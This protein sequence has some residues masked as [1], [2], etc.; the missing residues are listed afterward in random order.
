MASPVEGVSY[1]KI[2]EENENLSISHK[3]GET[4]GEA[5]SSSS[6]QAQLTENG[7][8]GHHQN[9]VAKSS[10]GDNGIVNPAPADSTWTVKGDGA[11]QLLMG[12]SEIENRVPVTVVQTLQTA[13][14]MA[15]QRVALGV[16]RNGV[17]VKW[18]YQEYYDSVRSAAKSFIKLGL[19]PYHGVAI[20]GF[21]APEW[22][23]SDLG[24]I[25][26]GGLAVGIYATNSPE[27]CHYVADN[28]KAN[29]I[30][31]ENNAQL[32]KILKVWNDLPEL[33]AVVQY[34]GEIEGER[35]PNVYSWKE[36]MKLGKEVADEVL[37]ARI[38]DLVPNK[39]CTLVYT[40]GTTGNPKGVMLS[41][42]NLVWTSWVG[43]KHFGGGQKGPEQ[44]ISYLPLSHIAAQILDI[45]MP[46]TIASSV[47]F[48]QPDALK[49]SLVN[50]FK[51]VRP[52]LIFGVPRVYEKI[53]EKMKAI[54]QQ[55]T[56]LKRK[57]AEYAKGVALKGNMNLEKGQ[58]LPFG[59]T[60]ATA[61]LKKVRVA[62]GLDRCRLCFVG[63][64][65]VTMETLRYFQSINIPLFELFGMSETSGPHSMSIPGHVVSGSCGIA[66]EGVKMKIANEDDDGN[67]ELCVKGRHVFMG[68]LMNEEKTKETLD[69]AGW[70]HSGDIARIDQNGQLFITGR[71]KE[72][73]ITAGGENIAPVPIENAIKAELPIINNAMVIGDKKKFLS[74]FL[75][76]QVNVNPDTGVPSDDLTPLAI[77]YCQSIGSNA[78]TVSEVLST[79]DEN[80]MKAIQEGIDRAN[81][82]AVSRAQKVQKFIILEKDF[83]LPG[84]ELGP[85]L[86]LRRP[87]VVKKFK[88]KI[89]S[90]YLD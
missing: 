17:W 66:M 61:L 32:Q 64:A 85:T 29:I 90:L 70:L 1:K 19:K 20:I 76:L 55:N 65:P 28:C 83:S 72:L 26:A 44:V 54:G 34:L 4:N 88:E 30:V 81:E 79:K 52:T 43:L 67:G 46:I 87:I 84:G 63:A 60:L 42:D 78:K 15:P 3:G 37:Q 25:F 12:S 57:I 35:P 13:V 82:H 14:R 75:T 80:V 68:Y 7:R 58:S 8:N 24:A 27:A 11:V 39:C 22:L 62:L 21:N 10:P 50:T 23:I 51:E 5:T 38:D 31:V 2:S 36:F 6:K 18:T 74:C 77:K 47:W 41:H 56:G 89:E 40:S 71:I 59:W 9:R 73:I 86:K 45:F 33:K 16:K 49:G 53:M 48:A 69:E